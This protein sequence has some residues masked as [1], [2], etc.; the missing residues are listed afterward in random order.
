MQV[1]L[2]GPA[3]RLEALWE[4]PADPRFAAVVCHPHPRFGGTLHNHATFRLAKAV[5]AL[6]GVT[7][8]FNYRGVGLSAGAYDDGHGETDDARAALALVAARRPDLPRLACGFSFGAWVALKAG[9]GDEAV[10]AVVCAGVALRELMD[11]PLDLLRSCP[12]PLAVVQAERDEFG[13]P[14]A[15]R[16]L[17]QGAAAP[18]ELVQVGG[19][20]HLFTEKL[21]EYQRACEEA[22]RWALSEAGVAVAAPPP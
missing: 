5:R 13:A 19:A 2:Q 3:G 14:E 20:T 11:R 18:R 9:A 7:L 22:L 4:E 21:P 6:G 17:L 15:V 10:R 16:E 1:E 8:R 12:K